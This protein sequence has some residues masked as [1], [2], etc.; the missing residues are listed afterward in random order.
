MTSVLVVEDDE[1]LAKALGL[2]LRA[3]GF[4]VTVLHTVN[5]A[6]ACLATSRV[7]VL[8][9]DLQLGDDDGIDLLESLRKI[10]P[11]TR[12]VLMSSFASARDYQ[13]AIEVGAVR[14]LCKPFTPSE[15]LQCIRQAVECETGFRGSVHGLSLIDMLQ[16]FNYGRRSVSIDVS[17]ETPGRLHVREGQIIHVEHD[18]RVGEAAL[19]SILSMP[20]GTLSTSAL[21]PV[22]QPTI[23]RDFRELL[24][25]A[26]REM[27]E[28]ASK[29]GD[30]D[31]ELDRALDVVDR[32]LEASQ[33][34]HV[35]AAP[36]EPEPTVPAHAQV[37]ERVRE[38][39]GYV[40]ACLV[41][42]QNGGVLSY[43][44]SLDLRPVARLSAEVIRQNQK[45]IHDMGLDDEAEDMLITATSQ[46]HLLRRLHSDVPAFVYLVLDR[47]LANPSLAKMALASAVR[48]VEL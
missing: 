39:D 1:M 45:T 22:P 6:L 47:R 14:V 23:A 15:L 17:G 38:I 11:R 9:T 36:R 18:G 33:P 5:Q 37:L 27:D 25:D 19:R 16:M 10:S 20:A 2:D 24:L 29:D 41:L 4:N 43:D 34:V 7:D 26:L 44:G 40:A 48:C 30:L 28:D 3:Q 46:Y 42:S 13:R 35:D 21:L 32:A 12:A 8:L 31:D